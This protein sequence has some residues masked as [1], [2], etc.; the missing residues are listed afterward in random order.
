MQELRILNIEQVYF[1]IENGVN[2]LKIEC[3]YNKRL[4]F[5]FTK[6]ETQK[7]FTKWLEK[8]KWKKEKLR[9]LS[10]HGVS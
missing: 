8:T 4:V 9:A 10:N 1:Y 6:E 5:V 2:P 3:G 7:L